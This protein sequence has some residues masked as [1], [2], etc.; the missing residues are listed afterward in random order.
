[1]RF[2]TLITQAP[3]GVFIADLQARCLFVNERW[4]QITGV[5]G[6]AALG[7]GWMQ[8]VHPEEREKTRQRWVP[9]I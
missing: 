8:T 9:L 7:D 3:V 2:R 1:M 6:S 5:P 4:S